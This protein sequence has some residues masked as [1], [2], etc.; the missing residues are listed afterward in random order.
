MKIS[1][2]SRGY[3]LLRPKRRHLF[4]RLEYW[5]AGTAGRSRLRL[6]LNERTRLSLNRNLSFNRRK[7]SFLAELPDLRVHIKI[8]CDLCLFH[9]GRV[10]PTNGGLI[11]C[12]SRTDL[13][14]MVSGSEFQVSSCRM[15][16]PAA[17]QGVSH[18]ETRHDKLETFHGSA[19]ARS[20][21]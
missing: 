7:R 20:F 1:P 5:S 6:R 17:N 19:A 18:V 15:E 12:V 10:P 3:P 8:S 21:A 4:Y 9:G 16:S 13:L 2:L 11:N 14:H